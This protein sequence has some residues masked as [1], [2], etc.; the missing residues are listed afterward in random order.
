[1]STEF[2]GPHNTSTDENTS[3]TTENGAQ[4]LSNSKASLFSQ[5]KSAPYYG[6]MQDLVRVSG[7]RNP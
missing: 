1:M 2:T 5:S 3:K 6:W 4:S 7:I